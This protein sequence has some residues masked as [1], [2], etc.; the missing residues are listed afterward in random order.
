MYGVGAVVGGGSI[1]TSPPGGIDTNGC[2]GKWSTQVIVTAGWV[3]VVVG[4]TVAGG[5]S[6][7]VLVVV[8]GAVVPVVGAVLDVVVGV[9]PGR[10]TTLARQP[11]A[12]W[13]GSVNVQPPPLLSRS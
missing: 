13:Y 2:S 7:V 8:V 10:I 5:R 3:V 1:A 11:G 12:A 6:G 4:G 9:W